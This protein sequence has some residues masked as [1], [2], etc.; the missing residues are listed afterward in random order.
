MNVLKWSITFIAAILTVPVIAQQLLISPEFPERG[1]SV[2]ITFIPA[3][4]NK[5]ITQQDTA[6]TLVFTYSN[7][8]NLPYRLPMVKKNDRWQISFPL[9]RYATYATFTLES[10]DKIQKPAPDKHYAIAVYEKGQRV[11]DGYLY[12]SY[13]LSAQMGKDPRVPAMQAALLEKELE[14]HPGNY[15]AKVRLLHNKMNQSTDEEK[16]KY[17]Q[18]ALKVIADN[19]YSNPGNPGNMNKTTMGYLIIGEKTRV[20]SIRDVIKTKYPTTEAGYDLRIADLRQIEDKEE[21]KNEAEAMLKIVA[22]AHLS[23]VNELHEILFEYY[24]EKKNAKQTL[25]HLNQLSGD[26]SPYRGVTLLNRAELLFTNNLLLD[27]ALAYTQR[28]AAIAADFPV[29]VIRYFPETGYILP[30]V[31]P[32]KK[33]RTELTAKG[34]SLSMMALVLLKKGEK[35]K[36]KE[37]AEQALQYSLDTKTLENTAAFYRQTGDHEQAYR[38][39]KKRA[40]EK[41][42]DTVASAQMKEDYLAWKKSTKGWDSEWMEVEDEWK[43]RILTV[44]Q[45]ERINKKIPD[46]A[47]LVDMKEQP[48]TAA[49]MA[50]KIVVIDFWATWCV[51]CMKEMPYLE[52]VYKKYKNNPKVMFM[53]L[54]SG[55]G[56]T[57]ADAQGWEGNKTYSFPVYYTNDRTLGEKFGFRVIPATFVIDPSGYIQFQTIGFEGPSIE[58]KLSGAIDLLLQE[59]Q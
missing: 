5:G 7:L 57:L 53:V 9:A 24:A 17:K 44:L 8:Y 29:G 51:P 32:E 13:S 28:A 23:Y 31:E 46:I 42:E 45:K 12:E 40:I 10:G 58:Y 48:V 11:P 59:M 18:G 33:R 27:T 15:E 20:D 52:K 16:E 35:Q 2:T 26:T 4:G 38:L 3:A 55:S 1:Q 25:Y 47:Y 6:V 49:D 56:N 36:A 34:N 41:Q 30:Y 43:K 21:R 50:G 54:N 14:L 39:T 37:A 19:F 22:P